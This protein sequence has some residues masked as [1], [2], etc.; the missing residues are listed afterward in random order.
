MKI[1]FLLIAFIAAV[2]AQG[3]PVIPG[4]PGSNQGSGQFYQEPI[5]DLDPELMEA[6]EEY[7][8]LKQQYPD[9]PGL[10]YN[11]GNLKYLTGDFP[12]AQQEYQN[13]LTDS[14][15]VLRSHALYNLGNTLFKQ[16]Q[17]QESID[18]YRQAL[19]LNPADDDIKYNYEI[20]RKILKQQQQQQ[21]SQENEQNNEEQDEQNQDQKQQQEEG[22]EQQ[23]DQQNQ[24]QPQDQESEEQEDG[25]REE[26]SDEEQE[27]EESQQEQS[28]PGQQEMSEE[29]QLGKEEAEAILNALKANEENLMKRKYRA[30]QR[31]TVEKDW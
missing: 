28:P 3:Q 9:V 23:Q 2:A 29:E 27:E 6:I 16:G 18:F 31:I 11:L 25:K 10:N 13:A 4:R 17:I 20:S 19:E 5:P 30:K 15:P 1:L 7:E 8:N 12:N 24:E 21:Q 26:Q 22:E 14:D